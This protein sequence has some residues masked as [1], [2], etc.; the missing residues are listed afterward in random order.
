MKNSLTK[1]NKIQID[2]ERK[3]LLKK[4]TRSVDYENKYISLNT[5]DLLLVMIYYKSYD[6]KKRFST[7]L[8]YKIL[9]L[10]MDEHE[11]STVLRNIRNKIILPFTSI[12]HKTTHFVELKLKIQK[13]QLKDKVKKEKQ[14]Y[15]MGLIGIY[16]MLDGDLAKASF[17]IRIK[18]INPIQC[19][20][21]KLNGISCLLDNWD[22]PNS[23]IEILRKL[24][25]ISSLILDS[26]KLNHLEIKCCG[27]NRQKVEKTPNKVIINSMITNIFPEGFSN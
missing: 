19:Q 20:Y 24:S 16:G 4:I 14:I 8:I 17:I 11:L 23:S 15:S 12:F 9:N 7:I 2:E 26:I 22:Q 25:N 5:E 1:E 13:N 27:I 10:D 21:L 6:Q 18:L 3:E